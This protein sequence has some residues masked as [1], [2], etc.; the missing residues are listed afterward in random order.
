MAQD[1]VFPKIEVIDDAGKPVSQERVSPSVMQFIMQ[2]AATAQLVK[3]RKIEESK[4]PIGAPSYEWTITDT[5]KEVQIANPWI[6]FYLINDGPGNIKIRINL[7][8]GDIS[9]ETTVNVGE[10]LARDFEYPVMNKLFIVVKTPG[11]T[12]AVRLFA[13]EGR[14]ER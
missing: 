12:A 3:M 13:E 14:V 10:T 5:I 4:I 2:A 6:S 1:L 7:L 11:T 9:G 8:E